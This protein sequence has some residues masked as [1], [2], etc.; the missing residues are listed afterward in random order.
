[1]SGEQG[2][3]CDW[4]AQPGLRAINLIFSLACQFRPDAETGQRLVAQQLRHGQLAV[5]QGS[6]QLLVNELVVEADGGGIGLGIAV[7]NPARPG[8]LNG[9]QAH[10]AGFATSVEVAAIE[11]EGAQLLAGFADGID[12]GVAGGVVGAGDLVEAAGDDC[13]VFHHHRAE[14]AAVPGLHFINRQANGFAHELGVGSFHG[15]GR[16]EARRLLRKVLK[17]GQ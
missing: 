2:E 12:F 11:L 8:P 5:G 7:E 6:V 1:M 13:A 17:N 4:D 15:W 16:G 3:R 14:G 9:P 10:G